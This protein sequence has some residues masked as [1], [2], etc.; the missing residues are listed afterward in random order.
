MN[1]QIHIFST[2]TEL[3]SGRTIDTNGPE[4]AG[5]LVESGFRVHGMSILPDDPEI[6]HDEIFSKISRQEV[7]AVIVTGGLGP[8]ADDHTVDVC[9]KLLGRAVVEESGALRKIEI[10]SKRTGGRIKFEDARRQTRI[11][12][13][14]TPVANT[15]GLAPGFI[16][17]FRNEKDRDVILA[18]LPGVPQEMKPMF[19]ETVLPYFKDHLRSYTCSRRVFYLYGLGESTFQ[20]RFFGLP[21]RAGREAVPGLYGPDSLSPEFEW[22]ITAG[23]GHLKIFFESSSENEVETL[24][25][26]ARKEFLEA[27]LHRPAP[28]LLH[29]ICIEKKI[30]IGG[31]ESCTGGLAGKILTDRA[32][33]S[34]FFNGCAVTYSNQAKH[35]L[36]DVPLE[37]LNGPGAV[38]EDCASSMAQG[39][40]K[41]LS[42]DYAFSITGIAGPDGGT[43]Q[44]PVGT[45]F[46]AVAGKSN[47]EV[48]R[49]V[50][51]MDRDRFRQYAANMAIFRL[52]RAIVADNL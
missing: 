29:E 14:A 46:M 40:I 8:T 26:A 51:P 32:G 13:G 36:L 23:H 1:S 3:S 17:H 35:D 44:K 41:R 50:L 33:S 39:A 7:D 9:A 12:E 2:G 43:P 45:V 34:A 16:T 49:F 24:T 10:I 11:V 4:I 15:S 27:F 22:G 37:I 18:A 28:D 38:S 31:A 48:F 42:C 19:L 25:Q 30:R 20:S 6:L 47:V 52:Y 21:G 5:A